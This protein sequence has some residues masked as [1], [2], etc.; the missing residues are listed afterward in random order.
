[1]VLLVRNVVPFAGWSFSAFGIPAGAL[2][3]G[4]NHGLADSAMEH[5]WVSSTRGP[6]RVKNVT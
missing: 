5:C 3:I 6:Q 4:Q 1:M 2:L